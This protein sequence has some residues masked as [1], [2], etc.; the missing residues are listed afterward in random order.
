MG[1]KFN[2][3]IEFFLLT[4][5]KLTSQC[6]PLSGL[7]SFHLI[8]LQNSTQNAPKL[9]VLSLKIEK[10]SGQGAVPLPQWGGGHPLPT[11]YSLPSVPRSSLT[12]TALDTHAFG[13]RP[14]NLQ[15]KSPPLSS[16]QSS[17]SSSSM[18]LGKIII[19]L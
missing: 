10:F 2:W 13:A 16:S 6:M 14:P 3:Q 11:P 17:S 19:L 12:P 15:Q 18:P 4:S 5:P 8:Q 7:T 1:N 9:A